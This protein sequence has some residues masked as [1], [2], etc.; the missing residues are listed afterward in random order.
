MIKPKYVI[1]IDIGGTK[2]AIGIVCNEKKTVIGSKIVKTMIGKSEFPKFLQNCIKIGCKIGG[3]EGILSLSMVCIGIPG[4]FASGGEIIL[5]NGS[6]SQ[7]IKKNEIFDDWNLTKWITSEIDPNYDLFFIND[8]VSQAIGGIH[9]IWSDQLKNKRVLY[10]GPGTGLGGAIIDVGNNCYDLTQHT[11]GHIYD[12]MIPGDDGDE[13]MAEDLI[14][15]RAV[16]EKCDETAKNISQS[17]VLWRKHEPVIN[18]MGDDLVKL[19]QTIRSGQFQKKIKENNWE[20]EEMTIATGIDVIL[21]GGSIGTIDPI[22]GR[23]KRILIKN[24]D[25]DILTIKD[26]VTAALVG[27]SI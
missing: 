20:K 11:D 13:K 19:I 23:L 27:T 4:N 16:Y 24:L 2:T 18:K 7:I 6:G 21:M 1:A 3:E 22:G 10:I 9:Q 5:K 14:S 25:L 15:G 17:D 8:A 12:I 26:S